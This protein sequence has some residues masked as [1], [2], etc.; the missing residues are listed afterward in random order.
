MP[1]FPRAAITLLI[2]LAVFFTSCDL[3]GDSEP[4]LDLC[5]KNKLGRSDYATINYGSIFADFNGSS[6]IMVYYAPVKEIVVGDQLHRYVFHDSLSGYYT[7]SSTDWQLKPFT[8]GEDYHLPMTDISRDGEKLLFC[9][10]DDVIYTSN[11][12]GSELKKVYMY[13][14]TYMDIPYFS[15]DG[16]KIAVS[17]NELGLLIM[18]VDGSYVRQ[19]MTGRHV[20]W[21]P[22]NTML[23]MTGGD[24][25]KQFLT[26]LD[27]LGSLIDTLIM[28]RMK[29]FKVSPD[30]KWIGANDI[31]QPY[32]EIYIYN[33]ETGRKIT[34][35]TDSWGWYGWTSD[36]KYFVYNKWHPCIF[37]M[38]NGRLWMSDLEGNKKQVS[39][40]P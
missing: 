5:Q 29:W 38:D 21:L 1:N 8:I 22:D 16:T 26:H 34:L 40:F 32:S 35:E 9:T 25:S 18:N 28:P 3:V 27:T 15:P 4:E 37:T 2:L 30:G 24:E 20:Q 10:I 23:L 6:D 12:D 14:E 17:S 31:V 7:M 13:P 11:R 39:F 33:I 19:L 36:S